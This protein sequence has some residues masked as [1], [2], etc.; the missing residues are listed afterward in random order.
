MD[1]WNYIE[2]KPGVMVGKPCIKGTR[3]TVEFILEELGGGRDMNDFLDSFPHITEQ[4]IRAALLFGAAAVKK[5]ISFA[6]PG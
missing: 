5:D 3:I 2:A 4:D 6:L 1:Y